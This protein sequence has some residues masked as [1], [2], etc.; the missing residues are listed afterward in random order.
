MDDERSL[1][2]C[3]PP[4]SREALKSKLHLLTIERS[5]LGY[6]E[7]KRVLDEYRE[8]G[9][10][11]SGPASEDIAK[12]IVQVAWDIAIAAIEK[13]LDCGVTDT[14]AIAS[15]VVD[16]YKRYVGCEIE[17][18]LRDQS[19]GHQPNDTLVMQ[20]IS[21]A[22]Y[23]G[24]DLRHEVEARTHDFLR[25]QAGRRRLAPIRIRGVWVGDEAEAVGFRT[26]AANSGRADW[27]IKCVEPEEFYLERT[28]RDVLSQC[29]FVVL[30]LSLPNYWSLRLPVLANNLSSG[31]RLILRSRTD[32]DS[33]ALRSFFD[34]VFL[35]GA[36]MDELLQR[37]ETPSSRVR[38]PTDTTRL[39][40][41]ILETSSVLSQ[42]RITAEAVL[43]YKPPHRTS[44]Q[45]VLESLNPPA[46][47][48]ERDRV[49]ISY[50][51]LDESWRRAVAG[52][53]G[54][55]ATQGILE[56]WDDHKL[57][58]GDFWR[59]ALR[60]A[61]AKSRLA[62]LMVSADFLTSDFIQNTE[63]PKFFEQHQAEGMIIFPV[64]V[65]PCAW[66]HVPW[67]SEMQIRPRD[68][69]ALSG[70]SKARR[71]KALAEIASEIAEALAE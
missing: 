64:L 13:C 53:L 16:D 6:S 34:G 42:D 39:I 29:N 69:V 54:V 1:I 57:R 67:L 17:P 46:R 9:V 19:R 31:T 44:V 35:P 62:L 71:E 37:A 15:H 3:A 28:A 48:V 60:E 20:L 5:K 63:V 43:A 55:L 8:R 21:G 24:D 14:K 56:T 68:A 65:R 18:R 2:E 33:A 30:P 12:A 26:A 7:A 45:P 25:E 66:K 58:G 61:M 10:I 59:V 36:L 11:A 52:H 40:S 32:A 51:H 22:R 23:R 47:Q 49:F 4:E 50:S 38:A 27:V 41:R 70:M